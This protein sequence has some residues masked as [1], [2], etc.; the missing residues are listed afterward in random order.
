MTKGHSDFVILSSF[1][2]RASSFI[3]D[4]FKYNRNP[5]VDLIDLAKSCLSLIRYPLQILA[6]FAFGQSI[7]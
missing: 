5:T 4:I 6:I 1:D 7:D 2:I 3:D